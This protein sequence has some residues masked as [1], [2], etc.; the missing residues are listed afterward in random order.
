MDDQVGQLMHG[1]DKYNLTSNTMIV[2][3]GDNGK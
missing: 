2:F 3:L 1:L